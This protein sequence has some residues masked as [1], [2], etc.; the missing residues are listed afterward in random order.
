M[1]NRSMSF[2]LY[3]VVLVVSVSS[4]MMG[5]DWLASPPPPIPQSVQTA[6]A[7]AKPAAPAVANK[8]SAAGKI[9]KTK[10]AKTKV[11]ET[12]AAE[13][14]AADSKATEPKTAA[15]TT[16]ATKAAEINTAAPKPVVA[17]TGEGS[18]A[19]AANDQA[20]NAPDT[21]SII[22]NEANDGTD[23]QANVGPRCD[24]P[25]C[26]A[27]YRSFNAADCTYQ[28]YDGPRRL[29]TVGTPPKQADAAPSGVQTSDASQPQASSSCNVQACAAA[30]RSFDAATCTWQPFDGPRRTCEK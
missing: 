3:V 13:T 22:A 8:A 30:Y 26:A 19:S 25:A 2:I 4:V 21:L 14:K 7:P 5:L 24:V 12:K 20:A 23:A 27:H 16:A 18:P 28:P 6:R 11:A 17:T 9:A 29:C 10:I 1:L 15:T